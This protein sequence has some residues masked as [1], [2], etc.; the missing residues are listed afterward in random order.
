MPQ[1]LADCDIGCSGR[2]PL[3][4]YL[5][6]MMGQWVIQLKLP[7]IAQLENGNRSEG[8]CYRANAIESLRRRRYFLF[9]VCIT[10]ASRPDQAITH[11]DSG[12]KARKAPAQDSVSSP[13][14]QDVQ[15]ILQPFRVLAKDGVGG[16]KQRPDHNQQIKETMP[17]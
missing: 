4:M 11:D 2:V 16:G 15:G 3:N 14:V 6:E 1:E 7:C 17:A 13:G 8:F 10:V 12:R 9:Q 5:A